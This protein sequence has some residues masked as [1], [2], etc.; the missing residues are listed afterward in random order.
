MKWIFPGNGRMIVILF[1]SVLMCAKKTLDQM[2]HI[3][4]GK[5]IG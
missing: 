5:D 1:M 4:A 2:V 3:P